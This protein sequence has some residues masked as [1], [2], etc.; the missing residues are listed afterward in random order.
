MMERQENNAVVASVNEGNGSRRNPQQQKSSA[1]SSV[2]MS[3]ST[4]MKP[5]RSSF[6]QTI[7]YHTM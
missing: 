3:F 5:A 7:R 6:L 2:Y 1:S 4:A